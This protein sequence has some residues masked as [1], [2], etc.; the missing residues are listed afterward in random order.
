MSYI[1]FVKDLRVNIVKMIVIGLIYFVQKMCYW[2]LR[3]EGSAL[4]D[5][6]SEFRSSGQFCLSF[7]RNEYIVVTYTSAHGLLFFSS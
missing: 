3:K 7:F 6:A 2:Q 5:A 1:L 4:A